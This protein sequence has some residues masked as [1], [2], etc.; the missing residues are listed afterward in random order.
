MRS[1]ERVIP[2]VVGS[3]GIAVGYAVR[4]FD[5]LFI[6]FNYNILAAQVPREV[7]RFRASVEKCRK[8]LEKVQA[9]LRRSSSPESAFLIEAH[10][11]ILQDRLF[12]D[13]IIEK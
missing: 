1:S 13:R 7:A 8:Q 10:V 6:S 3:A 5:P 4:A 11:L 9:Q 12:I 2:G